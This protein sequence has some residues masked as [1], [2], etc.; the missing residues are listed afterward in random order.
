MNFEDSIM[1][2][3]IEKTKLRYLVDKYKNITLTVE[4]IQDIT[5]KDECI[6]CY[7]LYKYQQKK[8]INE[9]SDLFNKIDFIK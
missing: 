5:D 7:Y 1:F 4:H 9:L 2:K 6:F 3:N 8:A